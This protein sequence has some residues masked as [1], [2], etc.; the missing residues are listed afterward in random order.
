MRWTTGHAALASAQRVLEDRVTL[1]RKLYDQARETGKTH[2]A[3]SWRSQVAE[4]EK[5][6]RILRTSI[7][8]LESAA[9]TANLKHGKS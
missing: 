8:R 5:E 4:F 9:A 1:G 6:L 3:E 2:L 7:A